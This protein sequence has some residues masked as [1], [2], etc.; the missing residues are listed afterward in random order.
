MTISPPLVARPPLATHHPCLPLRCRYSLAATPL[1]TAQAA[2]CKHHNQHRARPGRP[3]SV[4]SEGVGNSDCDWLPV[5][6]GRA[7]PDRSRS[8]TLVST[9]S[10]LV[11]NSDSCQAQSFSLSSSLHTAPFLDHASRRESWP[12]TRQGPRVRPVPPPSSKGGSPGLLV[13]GAD[14]SSATDNNRVHDAETGHVHITG[15][16]CARGPNRESCR[17]DGAAFAIRGAYV[18]PWS[19]TPWERRRTWATHS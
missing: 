7:V 13:G 18:A 5:D 14:G 16:L 10:L 4:I 2:A 12:A 6:T 11:V 9:S 1:L 8:R 17:A 19:P 15:H 3:A